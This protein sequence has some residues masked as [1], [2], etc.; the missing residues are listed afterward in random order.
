MIYRGLVRRLGD[1]VDTDVMI[2]G[3][4]LS[5][6]SP[7]EMAK[8][9]FEE[10]DPEFIHRVQ[11]G[12][13]IVAGEN[14]G[15]GSAREHAPLGFKALGISC[16]V[17]ASF[18]RTFYRMCVDLGLPPITCADALKFADEGQQAVVDTK[19]G[20]ICLGDHTLKALPLPEFIENLM[21]MGGLT[22]WVQ[23]QLQS[24]QEA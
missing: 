8:Y 3:R 20:E 1:N 2:A 12:D 16:I 21:R 17:A 14:F 18:S 4:H 19:S 5:L 7:A 15:S 23:Q 24:E 6:Q 11:P 10:T 13:I 9:M 22:N